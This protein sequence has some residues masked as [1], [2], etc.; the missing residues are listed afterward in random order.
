MLDKFSL[1]RWPLFDGNLCGWSYV[2]IPRMYQML[3]GVNALF[4]SSLSY[5]TWL[6]FTLYDY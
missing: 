3:E 6:Y 5:W 4:S 1:R 2:A